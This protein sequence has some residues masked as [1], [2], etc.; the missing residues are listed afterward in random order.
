MIPLSSRENVTLADSDGIVWVFS[1]K[2][3]DFERE[4]M[5]LPDQVE[6]MT[7]AEQCAKTDDIVDRIL[8]GWSGGP[9][10]MP[11]YPQD[12]KPSRMFSQVEKAE[13]ISMWNKANQLTAEEKKL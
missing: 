3:G 4:L 5:G 13:I 10:T 8:K 9:A 12:G 1:P 11:K 7:L 6:K 2:Y